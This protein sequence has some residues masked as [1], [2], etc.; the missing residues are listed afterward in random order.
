M[1]IMP[2]LAVALRRELIDTIS[3]C[4]P[5]VAALSTWGRIR[6]NRAEVHVRALQGALSRPIDIVLWQKGVWA[7]A[8]AA[9]DR[10][11]GELARP[12]DIET[13][14][15]L[16]LFDSVL[17]PPS[18]KKR[19]TLPGESRV[20]GRIL[21]PLRHEIGDSG[22][23]AGESVAGM[24][25]LLRARA[26]DGAREGLPFL[27]L[28]PDLAPGDFLVD[29]HVNFIAARRYLVGKTR[30]VTPSPRSLNPKTAPPRG[31]ILTIGD[32]DV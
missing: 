22:D 2:E 5:G 31:K 26:G 27:R 32:G 24:G 15:Q 3:Q 11:G 16:W 25:Y 14:G 10:I 17:L 9:R 20:I 1:L 12:D 29:P 4:A 7:T 18:V 6:P 19:F 30:D 28:L 8:T 13:V 23:S 21:L